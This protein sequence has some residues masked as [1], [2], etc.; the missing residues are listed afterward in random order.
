M[1]EEE[2][3]LTLAL[4]K[5]RG[6]THNMA[7]SLYRH[8][9]SAAA[10]FRHTDELDG[11]VRTALSDP[12][13]ALKHAEA[14]MEF[15]I[16]KGIRVL[17][18]KDDGFPQRLRECPDPPLSIFL[19]GHAD[20]NVRHTL[21]VVGTRRITEYG[22]YLC[23]R[24]CEDLSQLVPGLLV[25]SGLA[26]GVDIHAHRGALA[27]GLSTV[28]VLAH[29]LD[30]I[31]PTLHR[32]TARRMLEQGGLVTEYFSGTIPD[33][34]N[35]VRRNRIVAGLADAVLVV[36]SAE[37]G[38]ALITARLAQDYNRE[39]FAVPGR[40]GDPYSAGCN[41]LI[42]DNGAALVTSAADLAGALRWTCGKQ[43]VQAVQRELFPSLTPEEEKIAALLQQAE[44]QS[45][46]QLA[47]AANLPVH[48]VSATLFELEL[49][50]MVKELAGG[51]FRLLR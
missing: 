12:S 20:L 16:K 48:V 8:Y 30:R 4:A 33:K 35:F 9:G 21:A 47:I 6:I 28:A 11:K 3:L 36:E 14:E 26:Y 46:N 43:E 37:R 42:R 22:K 44:S 15:C 38:G 51:R 5:L 24:F 27:A 2:Q 41:A 32:D 10:V 19:C 31:Y 25:I 18:L 1:N 40:V 23:A 49:K 7:L 17:C 29:G 39:V 45:V 50:G 13:A 34:G